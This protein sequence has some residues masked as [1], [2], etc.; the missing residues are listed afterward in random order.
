MRSRTAYATRY[1]VSFLCGLIAMVLAEVDHN[2]NGTSVTPR[3]TWL[4]T[5]H[6]NATR[7]A[8][9]GLPTGGNP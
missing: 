9:E 5:I 7:H 8:R 3:R 6:N 4:R 1:T 2:I